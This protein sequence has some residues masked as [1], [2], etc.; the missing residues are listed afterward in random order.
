MKKKNGIID[1]SLKS[2]VC[3]F[4]LEIRLRKLSSIYVEE[5]LH[6]YKNS[7]RFTNNDLNMYFHTHKSMYTYTVCLINYL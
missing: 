7:G 6:K 4:L 5:A 2:T 3:L 1:Q